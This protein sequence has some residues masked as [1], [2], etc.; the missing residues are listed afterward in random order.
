MKTHA[1]IG[2]EKRLSENVKENKKGAKRR[3]KDRIL[4]AKAHEKIRNQRNDFLHKT[5]NYFVEEFDF[6]A[7]EKLKVKNMVRNNHLNK[8]ISDAGWSDFANI[9]TYK[10]KSAG[11]EIVKVNPAGTSQI[12]SG[13]GETVKKSLSVRVHSCPFCGLVIDRDHNAAKNIL[14]RA[15]SA[16]GR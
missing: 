9:L 13:C 12:C 15:G 2:T 5:A 16:V 6:I 8:S 10:A 14:L 4:V 3:N 7:I 11:R 1:I